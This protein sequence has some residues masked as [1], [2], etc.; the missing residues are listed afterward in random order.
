MLEI[1][2][3]TGYKETK[4]L[5]TICVAQVEETTFHSEAV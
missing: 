3:S 4:D 2:A 5:K 1:M